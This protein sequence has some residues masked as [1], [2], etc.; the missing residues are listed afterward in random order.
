MHKVF[1]GNNVIIPCASL[2][3]QRKIRLFSSPWRL[4]EYYTDIRS[5]ILKRVFEDVFLLLSLRSPHGGGGVCTYMP[6]KVYILRVIA[7]ET[8]KMQGVERSK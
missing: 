3:N 6:K 5:Y 4:A 8:K 7:Q 1:C 2:R